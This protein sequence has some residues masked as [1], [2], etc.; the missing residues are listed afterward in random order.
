MRRRVVLANLLVPVLGYIGWDQIETR[1][2]ARDIAAIAA[3]G[4]PTTVDA[5]PNG[6]DTTERY[7]AA[8]VYAAAAEHVRALPQEITFRLPR[9]D[10]DSGGILPA[11]SAAAA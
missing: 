4:E 10:V 3:R 6:G 2:L 1:A 7:Q 9:L 5:I 8:R 11:C